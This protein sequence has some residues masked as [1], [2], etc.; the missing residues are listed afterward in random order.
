VLGDTVDLTD[1][2]VSHGEVA[3][4]NSPAGG[5]S[6]SQPDPSSFPATN[7]DAPKELQSRSMKPNEWAS[8]LAQA[9]AEQSIPK[10]WKLYQQAREQCPG[11]LEIPLAMARHFQDGVTL[12]K[13]NPNRRA[14]SLP[15]GPDTH[16]LPRNK[17]LHIRTGGGIIP[18]KVRR[19]RRGI[20]VP[21]AESLGSRRTSG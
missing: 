12:E 19:I 4:G 2:R 6:T 11:R 8:L 5:N 3:P 9:D 14:G 10:A 16:A 21:A 18:A 1:G 13:D 20:S 17:A 15:G 7:P